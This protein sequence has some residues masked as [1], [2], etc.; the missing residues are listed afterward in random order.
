MKVSIQISQPKKVPFK[1]I[2]TL[3]SHRFLVKKP[4]RNPLRSGKGQNH[5][6]LLWN[7]INLFVAHSIWH[8]SELDD[9]GYFIKTFHSNFP[10]HLKHS[11]IME[12]GTKI[13][14]VWSEKRYVLL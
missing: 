12:N 9:V 5:K 13:C 2:M 1:S 11:T 4:C 14:E 7:N 6:Y 10:F 8:I 3:H